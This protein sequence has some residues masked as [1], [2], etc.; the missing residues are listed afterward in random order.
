MKFIGR[1]KEL[2]ALEKEYSNNNSLTIIYGRRRVGKT[3]LIR[4]FCKDKDHLY[5]LASNESINENLRLFSWKI[6]EYT[7]TEGISFT[8]WD[9]AFDYL[10]KDRKIIIVIDE[11][12]YLPISYTPF[13]SVMQRIWDTILS[14]RNVMLI[15]CGSHQGMMEK[16]TLNYSSPLYGR[17][18][19]SIKLQP[20][21][22][23][24]VRQHYNEYD[25]REA[26][27]RYAV[28]GGI[29]R[30]MELFENGTLEESVLDNIFSSNGLLYEEPFFLLT[31]EVKDPVNYTTI[32]KTIAAGNRKLSDIAGRM[33]VKSNFLS[34]YLS[35][36]INMGIL[37]RRV[38]VTESNP[39][40]SR[41]GL[42]F[43]KDGFLAFWFQF[44]LPYRDRLEYGDV[45]AA[46]YH[47]DQNFIDGRVSFVFEEICRSRI[48]QISQNYLKS[49]SYWGKD[50]E[51][52]VVAVD[53]INKKI[54]AGECK[55]WNRKVTLNVLNSLKEKCEKISAFEGYSI[56]YGIFSVSGFEDSLIEEAEKTGVL[57]YCFS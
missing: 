43:I 26:V 10:T 54:F 4:E 35:N 38:P 36:L 22:F 53:S 8:N 57:L 28:T 46:K 44:V 2:T 29:P 56:E 24:D 18:T 49:G 17:R 39:E 13:A 27:K 52:D 19:L 37:E 42:Y 1:T 55:F 15:L 9:S 33:E 50:G 41:H 12:Q 32:L 16:E 45:S 3:A 6:S 47:F 31:S 14:Q 51:I 20:L 48:L 7:E 34:P 30:Y 21:P 40:R 23:D 25:I 5:F 11:F